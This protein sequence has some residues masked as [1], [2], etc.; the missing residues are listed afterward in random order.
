[1]RRQ[2]GPGVMPNDRPRW[3][4]EQ[5]RQLADHVAAGRESLPRALDHLNPLDWTA[6]GLLAAGESRPCGD[7]YCPWCGDS[8]VGP[9]VP[10]KGSVT[11]RYTDIFGDYEQGEL[12]EEALHQEDAGGAL[13]EVYRTLRDK[14]QRKRLRDG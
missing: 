12:S 5:L 13:L 14:L 9:L 4:P 6:L 1:M 10:S 11:M 8:L 7:S 2:T 3:L